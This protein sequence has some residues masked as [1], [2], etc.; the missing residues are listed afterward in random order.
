M[1]E[2]LYVRKYCHEQYL[3]WVKGGM[4][5]NLDMAVSILIQREHCL[6]FISEL[7]ISFNHSVL[8]KL[9][10]LGECSRHT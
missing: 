9:I 10:G 1:D 2:N 6:C 3:F 5:E 8:L 4:S 7:I